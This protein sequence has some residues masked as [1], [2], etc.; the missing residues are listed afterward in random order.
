MRHDAK[1]SQKASRVKAPFGSILSRR[2]SEQPD[3]PQTMTVLQQ[4]SRHGFPKSRA[5]SGLEE[6]AGIDSG[7][8]DKEV[9]A[10][11]SRMCILPDDS[12]TMKQ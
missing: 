6:T 9:A 10:H 7:S 11:C 1:G 3:M 2:N 8:G 4:R 5:K 12:E